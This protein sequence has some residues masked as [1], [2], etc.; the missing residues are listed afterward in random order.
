MQC[1]WESLFRD[2]GNEGGVS[3]L[4]AGSLMQGL[5]VRVS[6]EVGTSV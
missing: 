6:L 4:G 3:W 5:R 2:V 1:Q